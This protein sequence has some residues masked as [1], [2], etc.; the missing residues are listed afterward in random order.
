[1]S[2]KKLKPQLVPKKLFAFACEGDA[3]VNL[4]GFLK[5]RVEHKVRIDPESLGGVE[6]LK[7][8]KSDFNKLIK[9][10][11]EKKKAN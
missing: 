1:M 4:I 2:I 3:E 10:N 5:K 9:A 7:R 6:N 8:F 11:S